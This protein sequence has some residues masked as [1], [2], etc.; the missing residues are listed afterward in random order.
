MSKLTF[1]TKSGGVSYKSCNRGYERSVGKE[2][3]AR[4][5]CIL[6]ICFSPQNNL[7]R[8]IIISRLQVRPLG[9]KKLK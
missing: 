2:K 6:N 1:Q 3:E 8:R 7:L 5:Y 9:L 4:H